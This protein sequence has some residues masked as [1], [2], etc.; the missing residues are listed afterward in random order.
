MVEQDLLKYWKMKTVNIEL[1]T[2]KK[3]L[4]KKIRQSKRLFKH[5]T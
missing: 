1:Y 2:Q 3:Y 5:E 4:T